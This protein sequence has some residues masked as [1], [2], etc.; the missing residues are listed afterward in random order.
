MRLKTLALCWLS[1][2]ARIDVPTLQ[3]D[4][5]KDITTDEEMMARYAKLLLVSTQEKWDLCPD[6]IGYYFKRLFGTMP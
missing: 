3:C 1:D 4:R 2:I 5:C 6:C